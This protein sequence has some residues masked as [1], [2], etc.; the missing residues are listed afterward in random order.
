MELHQLRCAVAVADHGTFTGAAGALH[1]TQPAVSYAVGKLE[2]ELGVQLFRRIGTGAQ[3]TSAGEA[4]LPVAR[5][6]I[7]NADRVETTM[8]K[9]TG[10][11]SGRLEVTTPRTLVPRMAS[12]VGAFRH[13]HAGVVVDLIDAEGDTTVL[14]HLRSS[15]C[16]LGFL[17]L[18]PLP[19]DLH[20][21]RAPDE[22][23]IAVFP[24]ETK[25][26]PGKRTHITL[27]ELANWPLVAPPR[28][29]PNRHAFEQL[30]ANHG[31]DIQV[32]AESA[33]PESILEL[34]WAGAGASLA[35]S[36]TAA[37]HSSRGVLTRRLLPPLV[38][39]VHLAHRAAQLSPAASAFRD[40]AGT[41]QRPDPT[42]YGHQPSR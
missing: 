37:A 25:L 24:P 22:E 15:R 1:V 27:D 2:R 7:R 34:V 18:S 16:E 32:V 41:P 5:D 28:A 8:A 14:E 17:R 33:H 3:L 6:T 38:Q 9:I 39:P 11:I 23:F 4:F 35:S 12:L 10:V 26:P 20:G 31:L 21:Q 42:P 36:D 13:E 30:F 40:L 19:N 29:T